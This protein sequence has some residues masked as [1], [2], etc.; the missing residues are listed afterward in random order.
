LQYQRYKHQQ[1]EKP[2]SSYLKYLSPLARVEAERQALLRK[3]QRIERTEGSSLIDSISITPT[4]LTDVVR[5]MNS[6]NMIDTLDQVVVNS[7]TN[8]NL[9][10]PDGIDE[11]DIKKSVTLDQVIAAAQFALVFDLNHLPARAFLGLLYKELGDFGQSEHH[12]QKVC[13]QQRRRGVSSGKT[14]LSSVFGGYS[15]DWGWYSWQLLASCLSE[16]GRDADAHKAAVY[17]LQLRQL[18]CSRGYEALS[19]F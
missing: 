19:R 4:V 13:T 16:L 8:L 7:M 9:F 10:S 6:L 15:S 18:S 5:T 11:D 12:L 17:S 14:G 1:T 3:T 2:E